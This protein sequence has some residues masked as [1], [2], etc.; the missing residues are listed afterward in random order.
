MRYIKPITKMI[1]P[2]PPQYIK[3]Y[4]KYLLPL[5]SNRRRKRDVILKSVVR[6]DAENYPNRT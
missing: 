5:S 4:A 2:L 3:W 1:R 6:N